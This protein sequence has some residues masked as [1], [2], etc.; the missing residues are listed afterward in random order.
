MRGSKG[1]LR[2]TFLCHRIGELIDQQPYTRTANRNITP[3]EWKNNEIELV[4]SDTTPFQDRP[5][6]TMPSLYGQRII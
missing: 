4:R 5:I 1:G 3:I 6:V 2:N